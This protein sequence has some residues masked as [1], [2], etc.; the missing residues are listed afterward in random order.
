M[1]QVILKTGGIKSLKGIIEKL[2]Q[3]MKM[4]DEKMAK[5]QKENQYL[6]ERVNK[7]KTR[8]RGKVLF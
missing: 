5:V 7:M 4:K 1:S 3:E 8:L 6:Q 2:Q